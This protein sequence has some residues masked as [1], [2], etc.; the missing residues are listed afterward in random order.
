M[1]KFL[2]ETHY[3][4]TFKIVHELD[5][6]N[7]K[8]LSEVDNAIQLQPNIA[9]AYARKGSIYYKLNQIDR[10]TLNWNIALKLDPEYSEVRDM[11]NALKENKL[12]PVSIGN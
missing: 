9:V 2:V 3:T 1:S 5:E 4:C 6:L 8:A 12:R 10:A 7:E 11:L